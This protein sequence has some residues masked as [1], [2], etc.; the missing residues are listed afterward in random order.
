M[1]ILAIASIGGH[2]TQLMRLKSL[3]LDID[4]DYVST[5]SDLKSTV[6]GAKFYTVA[7]GNRWNKLGLIKC[8][9]DL[10]IVIMRSKPDVIITTGAA[11]GV[12]AVFIGK[13]FN[14]KTIWIDSIANCDEIS[15]SCKIVSILASK[16]YTQWEHL[17]TK[18]I[19]F[20]GNILG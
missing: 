13:I 12:F 6:D 14:L 10:I 11:P 17:S 19:I 9:F 5:N 4:V 20:K 15:M 3:F 18:N 7:D 1:K 2:W 16:T 8:F